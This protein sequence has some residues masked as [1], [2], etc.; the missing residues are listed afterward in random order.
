MNILDNY[1]LGIAEEL[2]YEFNEM[3]N[4]HLTELKTQ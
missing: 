1:I 3:P 4:V 2:S